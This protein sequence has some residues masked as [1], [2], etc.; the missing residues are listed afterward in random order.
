MEVQ[1]INP[2][3]LVIPEGKE[4]KIYELDEGKSLKNLPKKRK[5]STKK[6]SAK[7]GKKGFKC[8]ICNT[9]F[10]SEH[11]MNGHITWTYYNNS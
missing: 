8:D 3:H 2:Q 10:M 6:K 7:E 11:G 4:H 9:P 1:E 5:V